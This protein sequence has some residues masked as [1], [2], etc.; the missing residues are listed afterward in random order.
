MQGNSSVPPKVW[1]RYVDDSFVIIKKDAVS[2]FHNT[3][4]ASD[5]KISFTI[6]LENNS[7]IAFLDTLVSRR[8]GVVV[9][10]VYRKPTH[11]DRYLDFSSHHD[12]KHKISTAS[13]LLFRA[14]SLPTSHEGKIRETSHV[15][16]ALEANGYPSSVISTILNKKPPS[17]TVPTPEELVSMFFKW[18]D[19]PD[20]H[21]G[22]A[23]LPYI[24]GLSLS[25]DYSVKMKSVL[26]TNLSKPFNKNSRLRSS[27]NHHISN[28]ML[29][30]KSHAKTVHGTT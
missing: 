2:S 30:I 24:S 9:I 21:K 11:T 27:D 3:L 1:K 13:T 10:D 25:R 29:F 18:V 14:S 28:P 15:I 5:P 26:S 19:P 6:E 20:T 23:C 17:P 22:F 16:A 12:K 7:Q 8:N 4:N